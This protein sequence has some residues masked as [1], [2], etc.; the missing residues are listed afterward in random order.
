V[1]GIYSHNNYG[2]GSP[3]VFCNITHDCYLGFHFDDQNPDTKWE[4]NHMCNHWAGLALTN[5]AVIGQQGTPAMASDN[6][7]ENSA[8]CNNWPSPQAVNETYSE[9]SDVS[10]SPLFVYHPSASGWPFSSTG[11]WPFANNVAGLPPAPYNYG[12]SIFTVATHNQ[13][14]V[15]CILTPNVV[16]GW[17]SSSSPTRAENVKEAVKSII[18]YPNP[19]SGSVIVAIE[20]EIGISQIRVTDVSGKIVYS[21]V[22]DSN[23][24]M[25][26]LSQL[27]N[28]IYFME[29]VTHQN[30]SVWKKLII[31]D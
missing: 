11:Y 6:F 3:K 27:T 15:D 10:L 2:I 21:E 5:N 23:E 16:P 31:V 9:N 20:S 13:N 14:N 28:G 17:K 24:V 7:W 22:S 26:D 12:T 29:V 25:I 19:T 18:V 30:R 4:G 8:P 1:S